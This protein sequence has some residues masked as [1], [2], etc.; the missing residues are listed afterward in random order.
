M[1]WVMLPVGQL[2]E[3]ADTFRAG[4][5]LF[6]LGGHTLE[7]SDKEGLAHESELSALANRYVAAL[8]TA[9]VFIARAVNETEYA[10][11]EEWFYRLAHAT[12]D[13]PVLLDPIK[14]HLA[15][16]A[17]LNWNVETNIERVRQGNPKKAEALDVIA[18]VM[19]G[20]RSVSALDEA[21]KALG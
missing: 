1:R 6:R 9:G 7:I 15:Q 13:A 21:V 20:K 8:R 14:S 19:R 17:R 2:E 11:L 5:F 3:F 16:G 10:Q 18:Q 12:S 4:N